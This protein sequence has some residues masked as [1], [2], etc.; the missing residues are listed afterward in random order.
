MAELTADEKNAIS[1]R[2]D[3]AKSLRSAKGDCR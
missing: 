2:A 3:A 1:H